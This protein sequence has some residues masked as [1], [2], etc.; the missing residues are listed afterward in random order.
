[1]QGAEF[2][3][4]SHQKASKQTKNQNILVFE[5][6]GQKMKNQTRLSPSLW[7]D[8]N[9]DVLGKIGVSKEKGSREIK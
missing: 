6:R 9:T 8:E 4:Q 3:P 7:E 2:K 1:V 5:G